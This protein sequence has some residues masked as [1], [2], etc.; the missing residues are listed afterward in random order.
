MKIPCSDAY[1]LICKIIED[2]NKSTNQFT[3]K[4]F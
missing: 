1:A 4:V 3:Q 2:R